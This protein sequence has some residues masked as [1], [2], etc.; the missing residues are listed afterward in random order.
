MFNGFGKSKGSAMKTRPID[1][2]YDNLQK[3]LLEINFLASSLHT[4]LKMASDSLESIAA[5]TPDEQKSARIEKIFET[6]QNLQT[7]VACLEKK[8]LVFEEVFLES[9]QPA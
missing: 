3:E 9:H 8:L 7:D 1:N 2:A 4:M 5:A 6:Y